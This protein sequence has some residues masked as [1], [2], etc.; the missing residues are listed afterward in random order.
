MTPVLIYIHIYIYIYLCVCV[1]VCERRL[2]SGFF[3][4]N[5]TVADE[6]ADAVATLK[7]AETS[8]GDK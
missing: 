7:P 3:W 4:F 8:K 5:F 2:V 6:V 1:C